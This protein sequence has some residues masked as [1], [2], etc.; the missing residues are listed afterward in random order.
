MLHQLSFSSLSLL[1]LHL[2]VY[3][4]GLLMH[5]AWIS[6]HHC[7]WGLNSVNASGLLYTRHERSVLALHL[8]RP[9]SHMLLLLLCDHLPVHL[10][11]PNVITILGSSSLHHTYWWVHKMLLTPTETACCWA[12]QILILTACNLCVITTLPR[13]AH[14]INPRDMFAPIIHCIVMNDPFLQMH[15]FLWELLK[16]LD[17][18]VSIVSLIILLSSWI[19]NWCDG[20][21]A[22]DHTMVRLALNT[23]FLS[24]SMR[25]VLRGLDTIVEG[26]AGSAS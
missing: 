2:L 17:T 16:T 7:L 22:Y 24:T 5:A 21:V 10:A 23:D 11:S 9:I 4:V 15:R 3:D 14:K 20:I 26:S 18:R 13:W 8:H 25:A 6:C 1:L 12:L 19:D